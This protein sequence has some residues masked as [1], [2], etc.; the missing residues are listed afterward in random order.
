MFISNLCIWERICQLTSLA[1]CN[2]GHSDGPWWR[3]KFTFL[4]NGLRHDRETRPYW[5]QAHLLRWPRA[6]VEGRGYSQKKYR[7]LT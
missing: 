3:L 4:D 1:D 2:I 7:I 6:G 5:P